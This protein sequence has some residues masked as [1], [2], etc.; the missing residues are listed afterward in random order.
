MSK[1]RIIRVKGTGKMSMR[2]DTTRLTITLEGMNKDYGVTLQQ[3]SMDTDVLKDLMMAFGFERTDLKTLNFSVNTEYE[4]YKYK[5]EYKQRFA[6][7]KYY[8]VMKLEFPSE[9]NGSVK[10][11]MRSPIATCIR[12]FGSAIP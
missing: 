7:Y 4:S 12:S 8:H 10:S 1:K 11:S 5:G 6:G 2:P 3:S 9:T